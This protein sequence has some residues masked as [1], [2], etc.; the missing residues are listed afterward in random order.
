[1]AAR[2]PEMKLFEDRAEKMMRNGAATMDEKESCGSNEVSSLVELSNLPISLPKNVPRPT[3]KARSLDKRSFSRQSSTSSHLS[4][5]ESK[6]N[7]QLQKKTL[8]FYYQSP[9]IWT[10]T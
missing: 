7:L 9:D 4:P 2:Q 3:N 6:V 5:K 8:Y 10:H 1:M